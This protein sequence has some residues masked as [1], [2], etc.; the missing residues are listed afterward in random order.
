MPR[1]RLI[2]G[3]GLLGRAIHRASHSPST[4]AAVRWHDPDASVA[5]LTEAVDRLVESPGHLEIYWC[6]GRGVTAT[7]AR[8]LT[9]EVRVFRRFLTALQALP[10]DC[11]SRLTVFLASSVGGAYAGATDPPF[12]EHTPPAP[13]SAYGSAKLEMEGAL[14]AAAAAGGLRA[15]IA[16][17]T[18][19][20]GPGQDLTKAQ[21]LISV[22]IDGEVSGRPVNVY[23]PLDTL[24]DYIYEDDA[25]AVIDAAMMR[26]GVLDRGTRVVK[27]VGTMRA[28]S[29]G[30]ILGEITRLRRRRGPFVLG[31]GNATGQAMDL[32]V[33][34]RVWP[35][36]DGLAR[37]TLPEGLGRV[38]LAR[39][40]AEG[41]RGA[42]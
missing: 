13:L 3:G 25:A 1:S 19:I 17:L 12:S 26:L 6:A 7:P 24:R 20:Y 36:L 15:F 16:R 38:F 21:G 35:D 14:T 31:Q 9:E 29:V 34:S 5:D 42:V 32:R 27:V 41:R 22:L 23:V 11:R 39:L 10:D 37:T 33:Q 8:E 28:V 4:I 2:I 40:A 18:N 30:A